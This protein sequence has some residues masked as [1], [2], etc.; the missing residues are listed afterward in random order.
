MEVHEAMKRQTLKEPMIE[1]EMGTEAKNWE[2]QTAGRERERGAWAEAEGAA[3]IVIEREANAK[4]EAEGG[5][6]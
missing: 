1:T 5:D 2:R 4:T 3:K 6:A